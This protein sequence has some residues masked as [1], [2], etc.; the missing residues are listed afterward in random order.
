VAVVRAIVAAAQP[1]QAAQGL[2]AQ[3][4]ACRHGLAT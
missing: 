1:E 4:A 2:M 3:W